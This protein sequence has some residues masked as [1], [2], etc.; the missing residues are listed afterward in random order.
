MK[1][2]KLKSKLRLLGYTL[3]VCLALFGVGI[4]G[5]PVPPTNKKEDLIEIVADNSDSEEEEEKTAEF[6]LKK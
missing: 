5:T 4:V 3:L 6:E 1:I 2:N